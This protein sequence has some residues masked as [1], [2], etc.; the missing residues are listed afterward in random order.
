MNKKNEQ[1]ILEELRKRVIEKDRELQERTERSNLIDSNKEAL[2]EMTNLS[3]NDVDAIEKQIRAEM[4][5][6]SAKANKRNAWIVVIS[7]VVGLIIS[8]IVINK[9]NEE[10]PIPPMHFVEKFDNNNNKWDI[11][12]EFEIK[13]QI[14][15]GYYTFHANKTDWCFWDDIEI[16]F[17]NEYS[18]KLVSKWNR[19]TYDEYGLMLMESI[20][21]FYTF[22][23]RADGNTA[24]AIYQSAAWTKLNEWKNV[25]FSQ[26]NEV[27]Q[28]IKVNN[29]HFAHYVNGILV[30]EGTF[31][32]TK[33]TAFA[34]RIC[35][36]QSVNFNSIEVK[37]TQT[38][39]VL[40][41]DDFEQKT[42]NSMWEEK[43]KTLKESK[44]ENGK[45]ILTTNDVEQCYWAVATPKIEL[46]PANMSKYT[47]R[48]RMNW[49]LGED[50]NF[51]IMLIADD[52]NYTAFQTRS[53]GDSR[54]VRSENN[55]YVN[56][57]E[58][59]PTGIMS[60]EKTP[61]DMIIKVDSNNYDF[62]INDKLVTSGDFNY[63]NITYLGL[64]VCGR[65]TVAFDEIEIIQE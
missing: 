33:M 24:Q 7:I 55:E 22:V 32:N 2:V 19:G 29:N 39:K 21:N 50:A 40:F 36:K 3:R 15:N 18:I 49:I 54:A 62:Y 65:Q 5:V 25:G 64:R 53:T 52:L 61:I 45:Y 60:D 1:K 27:V 42:A 12:N 4:Q 20:D 51:G 10:P 63:M 41:S 34:L 43:D 11:F 17:P 8:K 57:P 23:I 44:F 35:D 58:F 48:V 16:D 9:L 30:H 37:N 13:R 26:K 14:E 56:I 31:Q 28:E 59:I 46:P 38:G 47:I 6:K